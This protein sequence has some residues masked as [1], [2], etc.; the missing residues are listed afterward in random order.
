MELRYQVDRLEQA[1][2]LDRVAT[3][4]AHIADRLLPSS[5]RARDVLHGSWLG[6]PL[7]PVLTDVALGLY[8]GA[9][10]LDL[11][12]G[13]RARPA[14]DLL[15]GLGLASAAPTIVT[16]VADWVALGEFRKER[17]V[18]LV[19]AATNAVGNVLMLASV[20]ARLRGRRATGRALGLAG[21]GAAMGGGYLGGHL[22]FRQGVGADHAMPGSMPRQWTDVAA[23]DDFPDGRLVAADAGKVKIVVL[24]QGLTVCALADGCS[25]LGGPLSAGTLESVDGRPCVTCP[26]HASTFA[27]RDGSVV[28]GPATAP[29]PAFETRV[30]AGRLEVRVQPSPARSLPTT[31]A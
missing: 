30:T 8:T 23:L 12:G 29:Q 2:W 31:I 16:G 13:R 5:R 7:H 10:T 14:A 11:A 21:F 4:V 26:W 6:H 25:H 9:V 19:H 1:A 3:P 15:L 27:L 20:V 28:H 17:R 22:A 18:G 24:R